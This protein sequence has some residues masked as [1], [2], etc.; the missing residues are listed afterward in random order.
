LALEVRSQL[1]ACP[2]YPQGKI[3]QYSL[4]RRLGVLQIQSGH[5]VVEKNLSLLGIEHEFPIC[6]A[7][8]LVTALTELY[9]QI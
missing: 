8:S 3:P 1:H 4:D 7:Y 6:S 2:L 9:F 5:G